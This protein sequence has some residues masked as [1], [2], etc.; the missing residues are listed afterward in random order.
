MTK[1]KGPKPSS[2][3]SSIAN[4][5]ITDLN[6]MSSK[7]VVNL[8]EIK[9]GHKM[10]ED[11]EASVASD[12]ELAR[13]DPLHAMYVFAQNRMDIL[14]EQLTQLPACRKL[15][16]ALAEAD[17]IYMPSYPPISP[18]TSSYFSC[19]S[20]LDCEIGKDKESL[21]KI[22]IKVSQALSADPNLITLYQRMQESRM[23][24]YIHQGTKK[25]RVKLKELIT[26]KEFNC[27]SPS[28]YL[29]RPG[30][31]WFARIFPEPFPEW[32]L[33]YSVVFTTPYVLGKVK[34]GFFTNAGTLDD[35]QLFLER[36]LGQTGETGRIEAYEQFMKYGLNRHFWNEFIFQGYANHTDHV[37]YLAG[38][39]D[40]PDTL[41]HAE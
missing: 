18:V 37:V 33:G 13:L 16:S 12:K 2:R 9:E 19:W 6:K 14:A 5:I 4:K 40:R 39:P 38:I 23:G 28:G 27:I 8:E 17:D 35:W 31:L 34:K 22:A 36:T 29:G 7:K 41:P 32:S 11:L 24:L 30:E 1:K 21:A 10:A 15:F 25:K 26:E 3:R 20:L